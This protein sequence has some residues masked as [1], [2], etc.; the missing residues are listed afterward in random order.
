MGDSYTVTELKKEALK[1]QRLADPATAF[2]A[3]DGWWDGVKKAYDLKG[4]KPCGEKAKADVEAAENYKNII[5]RLL[6][7][8]GITLDNLMN[9][10]ESN[11]R[12][13]PKAG[14][15]VVFSEDSAPPG[16][17]EE[18]EGFTFMPCVSASGLS[19]QPSHFDQFLSIII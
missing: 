1:A 3:S 6:T 13:V 4:K 7:L 12:L 9:A 17:G 18:K 14:K 2:T 8:T 19:S 15:A 5:S 10:D 11:M 16:R